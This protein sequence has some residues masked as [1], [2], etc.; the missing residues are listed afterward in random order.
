MKNALDLNSNSFQPANTIGCLR[1]LGLDSYRASWYGDITFGQRVTGGVS[2]IEIVF[3]LCASLLPERHPVLRSIRVPITLL[4]FIP[5]GS[6]WSNGRRVGDDVQ[7]RKLNLSGLTGAGTQSLLVPAGGYI[8]RD[9]ASARCLPFSSFLFHRDHTTSMLTVAWMPDGTAVAIP[10]AEL[11]RFYFGTSG[12]ALGRLF[13]GA[14]AMEQLWTSVGKNSST[15]VANIELAQ[16]L[17]GAAAST[18]AR[19]ALDSTA[20]AAAQLVVRSTIADHVKKKRIYPKCFFPFMG[21]TDLTVSG[22]WIYE[23]AFR[24]FLVERIVCC[25]HPFPFS[26]LFYR[27]NAS[28]LELSRTR[29]QSKDTQSNRL[30]SSAME[31]NGTIDDTDASKSKSRRA[32]VADHG[33]LNPFPDLLSKKVRKVKKD[34]RRFFGMREDRGAFDSEALGS[35]AESW[36]SERR[37]VEAVATINQLESDAIIRPTSIFLKTVDLAVKVGIPIRLVRF[38]KNHDRPEASPE[39]DETGVVVVT[40]SEESS[41]AGDWG[42]LYVSHIKS[43]QLTKTSL[44]AF[45]RDLTEEAGLIVIGIAQFDPKRTDEIR[46]IVKRLREFY[47]MRDDVP[48]TAPWLA[49]ISS[50]EVLRETGVR[51]KLMFCIQSHFVS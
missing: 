50:E 34:N 25:S 30:P 15:G 10:C 17:N 41:Y 6:I 2:F 20:R 14:F 46:W 36:R 21:S 51:E 44:I 31:V 22:R 13:S 28:T 5:L 33:D 3:A 32:L 24:M 18:V 47:A 49:Q 42:T 19:I 29:L 23:T 48:L 11:I 12:S 8:E 16:G 45:T 39:Y 4:R 40:I 38:S 27:L 37:G 26:E 7:M 1:I 43:S 35:G 9:N